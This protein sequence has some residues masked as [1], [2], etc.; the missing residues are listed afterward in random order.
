MRAKPQQMFFLA[1]I[2][3]VMTAGCSTTK[4]T[5]GSRWWHAFTTQYNVYYNG[6]QA[7]IAGSL[8]KEQGNKDD[9]TDFIPLYTVGNNASRELGASDYA[10]AIE[11]SK[12]ALKLHSIKRRPQWTKNRRKTDKDREWLNRKEYN[13]T[14]WKAWLLLGRSQF[15]KGDFEDA[16]ATFAHT[17]WLYATQPAVC[18]KAKAWLARCYM[19]SDRLYEAEDVIVKAR[20]KPLHWAAVREWDNT[21]ADWFLH[22]RQWDSAAVYLQKAANHE[23]RLKQRARIYYLLGQTE[24]ARGRQEEA[25]RAFKHVIRL[26][27]PYPLALHARIAMSVTMALRDGERMIKK[28]RR[29]ARQDVNREYSADIAYAIGNSYLALGDTAQAVS[30]YMQV[31]KDSLNRS[32]GKGVTLAR[33]GDLCWQRGQYIL[34]DSCYQEALPLVGNGFKGHGNIE[35]RVKTLETFVPALSVALQNNDD[36]TETLPDALLNAGITAKDKIGDMALSRRLLERIA[37]GFSGYSR[38]DEALYHLFLLHLRQGDAA[39]SDHYLN[40]LKQEHPDSKWT[41]VLSDPDYEATARFGTHIEDSLYAATYTAFKEGRYREVETN[42]R[43]SARRFPFGANRDKF[44]FL[45][46][47][48]RLEAGNTKDCLADMQTLTGQYPE[49]GLRETAETIIK[50]L[51]DGRRV[52]GSGIAAS[53]VWQRK[54]APA[55]AADTADVVAFSAERGGRFAFLIV[56]N[57][58]SVNSN[59]LLFELARYNFTNFLVRSFAIKTDTLGGASRMIVDGFRGYDEALQYAR[60]LHKHEPVRRLTGGC[61]TLIVS[62]ENL[63]L[64][65]TLRSYGDYEAFYELHFGDRSTTTERLLDKPEATEYLPQSKTPANTPQTEDDDSGVELAPEDDTGFDD[66]YYDLEGF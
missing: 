61:S 36:G 8:A 17:A 33:L 19:Y 22:S 64:L 45:G 51:S 6:A 15:Q 46:G 20:R 52:Y 29:M 37:D 53:D 25:C 39:Q 28:L 62:E 42:A 63:S 13:P 34:A 18:D 32:Y 12:K 49:S 3:L 26:H 16:A 57:P 60:L 65:G 44:L 2:T 11:K 31:R 21:L 59:K 56:Y 40:L 43:L 55:A 14:L 5:R 47:M 23:M 9:Y 4:N 24:A 27:P 66:E 50:G 58:D 10:V 35:R 54:S 30:A 48:A 38:R 7:Y 1:V 41:A